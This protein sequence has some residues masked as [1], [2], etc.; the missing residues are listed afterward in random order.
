MLSFF[1]SSDTGSFIQPNPFGCLSRSRS[2]SAVAGG[3]RLLLQFLF[4][5]KS[6][7]TMERFGL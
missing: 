2:C 7:V 1:Y 4:N 3:T 5:E 6:C